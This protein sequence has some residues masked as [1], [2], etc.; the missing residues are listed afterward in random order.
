VQRYPSILAEFAPAD[1]EHFGLQV[2]ILQLEV[3]RFA[4]AKSRNAE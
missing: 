4:N 2:E 3:A 1:G